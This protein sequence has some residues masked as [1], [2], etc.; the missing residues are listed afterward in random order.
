MDPSSKSL[1][2]TRSNH[3]NQKKIKEK[4]RGGKER[5]L[6]MELVGHRCYEWENEENGGDDLLKKVRV[7]QY[8]E[9][10]E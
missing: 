1:S 6:E 10:S 5:S 9:R 2:M 3:R 8:K 7:G 4:I